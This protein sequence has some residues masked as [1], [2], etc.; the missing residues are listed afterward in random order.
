MHIRKE[1]RL[2]STVL[3][4]L[5]LILYHLFYKLPTCCCSLAS[6]LTRFKHIVHVGRWPCSKGTL[7]RQIEQSRIGLT[8]RRRRQAEARGHENS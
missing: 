5:Q 6:V 4:F 1:L 7:L 8:G 3:C 2:S